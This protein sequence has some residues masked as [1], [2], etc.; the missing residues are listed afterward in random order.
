MNN[1]FKEDG[2]QWYNYFFIR[3][4][5]NIGYYIAWIGSAEPAFP[6]KYFRCGQNARA[7]ISTH[8]NWRAAVDEKFEKEVLG[9][10]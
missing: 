9:G 4:D 1:L 6:D 8:S 10:S 3:L 7:W 2:S 5:F